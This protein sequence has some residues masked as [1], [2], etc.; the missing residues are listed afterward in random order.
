MRRGGETARSES[1]TSRVIFP[2]LMCLRKL[3]CPR[4]LTSTRSE[5]KWEGKRTEKK[6][7]KVGEK[8][9]Q[10]KR[11]AA[12]ATTTFPALACFCGSAI[13]YSHPCFS[14]NATAASFVSKLRMELS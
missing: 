13:S 11:G 2:T 10:K 14:Q 9:R 4:T 6:R 1:R 3:T 7:Q 5:V 8:K 12:Y